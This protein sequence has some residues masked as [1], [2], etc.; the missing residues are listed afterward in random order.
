M[1]ESIPRVVYITSLGHSGSTLLDLLL[2]SHSRMLG[3]GEVKLLSSRPRE[4]HYRKV[5]LDERTCDCGH[6]P[7]R[8]CP[9]WADVER[10]L[11]RDAGLGLDDLELEVGPDDRFAAHHLAFYRAATEASGARFLVDS[12][13][14]RARLARLLALP[15]LDVR[16]IHL[17]RDP[18]GL[19]WSHIKRGRPWRKSLRRWLVYER[20]VPALLE[21]R[22]ALTIDYETLATRPEAVL[23]EITAWLGL[24]FEPGQLDWT[25]HTHHLFGGNPIRRRRDKEIRLDDAWRR[26]LGLVPKLVIPAVARLAPHLQRG[27]SRETGAGC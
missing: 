11:R 3:L 23:R 12:S 27:G 19:A 2:S 13:M 15:G 20:N 4:L 24:E 25:Q 18:R 16:P 5:S 17:R 10:I 7:R 9:F 22:D 6:R 26:E 14:S 21:G 1:P 8:S